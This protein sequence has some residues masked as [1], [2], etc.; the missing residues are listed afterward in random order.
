M[1]GL[2]PLAAVIIA[3]LLGSV[4]MAI[5]VC[6]LCG[7]PDPRLQG[8]HNPGA[9]NVLRLGGKGAALLTLLG[10]ALKGFLPIVVMRHVGAS[11][12]LQTC[13]G[14]AAFLGHLYPLYFRFR[15]GKGVATAFGL[16]FAL[17]PWLGL[18]TAATWLLVFVLRRISSLAALL[19]FALMPV[20]A[21]FLHAGTPPLLALISL[22]LILRH[23]RNILALWRGEEKRLQSSDGA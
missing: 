8:S 15:G 1:L 16:I 17:S 14:L 10:D 18:A 21:Y 9:T 22:L 11:T 20:Y 2:L 7:L 23:R 13:L 5:P 6:A 19:A 12:L 4:C 3:Y